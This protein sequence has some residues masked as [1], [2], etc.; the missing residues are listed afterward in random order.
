MDILSH[1]IAGASSG[2]VFGRPILGM[3]FGVLPDVVLGVQ[4]KAH[5]SV[6]YNLTHSW[7]AVAVAGIAAVA[8]DTAAPILAVVSHIVLD[9]P[10]HGKQWAPPLLFPFSAKRYSMGDDWEWGNASWQRGLIVTFIWSI[11][12]LSITLN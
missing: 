8:F 10:T 5:P 7:L 6:L 4:R 12:C 2:A 3:V 9:L 11:T 1:A